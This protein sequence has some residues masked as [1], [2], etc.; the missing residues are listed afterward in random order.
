[1]DIFKDDLLKNKYF[2]SVFA[3]IAIIIGVVYL[4]KYNS[5]EAKCKRYAQ[6]LGAMLGIGGG[7]ELRNLQMQ[8]ASESLIQECIKRGGP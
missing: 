7:N 8:S 1:M 2:V 4:I 5:V 6:G 3:I